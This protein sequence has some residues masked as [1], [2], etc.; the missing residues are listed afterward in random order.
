MNKALV[1]E[2]NK[3]INSLFQKSYQNYAI[4]AYFDEVMMEGFSKYLKRSFPFLQ[5]FRE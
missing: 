3:Y 1:Y 4:S 2:I 5:G